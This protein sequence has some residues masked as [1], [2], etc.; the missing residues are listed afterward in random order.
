MRVP[1][2][3]LFGSRTGLWMKP[4]S[5]KA[6]SHAGDAL[7]PRKVWLPKTVGPGAGKWNRKEC[8]KT[9]RPKQQPENG[10]AP[11]LPCA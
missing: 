1:R 7:R 5:G 4:K 9:H 2:G 3:P 11:T 8:V 10:D 6:F